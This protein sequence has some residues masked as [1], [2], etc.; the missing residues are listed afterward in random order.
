MN[1]QVLYSS[2]ESLFEPLKRKSMEG[3]QAASY[4]PLPPSKKLIR[5][6]EDAISVMNYSSDINFYGTGG[7][8]SRGNNFSPGQWNSIMQYGQL[9]LLGFTEKD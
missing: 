1:S 3:N 2:L 6:K 9:N 8:H 7:D 5:E 4:V